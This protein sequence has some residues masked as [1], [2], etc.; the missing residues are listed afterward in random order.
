[1]NKIKDNGYVLDKTFVTLDIYIQDIKYP[2]YKI[3]WEFYL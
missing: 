1:M 2:G 3:K